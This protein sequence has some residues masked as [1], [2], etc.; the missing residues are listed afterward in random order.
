MFFTIVQ[1]IL[2]FD[3]YAIHTRTVLC[4]GY[5][6]HMKNRNTCCAHRRHLKCIESYRYLFIVSLLHCNALH[7][8]VLQF[9]F[10]YSYACCL[11]SQQEIHTRK[12]RKRR[13]VA[14]T[15]LHSCAL[16]NMQCMLCC[17]DWCTLNMLYVSGS[18]Y[19]YRL[20]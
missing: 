14:I 18:D 6:K 7:S 16:Y 12:E 4:C 3:E 1:H 5:H 19:I 10:C 13:N 8:L 15:I 11:H 9:F 20:I 2:L 17:P